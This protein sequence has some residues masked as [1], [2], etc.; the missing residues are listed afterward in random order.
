[1]KKIKAYLSDNRLL[2][3]TVRKAR[4]K[5]YIVVLLLTITILAFF[6]L[7]GEAHAQQ[8]LHEV[9]TLGAIKKDATFNAFIE[10]SNINNLG[11]YDYTITFDKKVLHCQGV[12][13][14][15]F[16]KDEGWTFDVV[17]CTTGS[18]S[19]QI[20][21]N[22]SAVSGSGRM[23]TI[24]FKG[25]NIGIT[26][27]G[28][29]ACTL[30]DSGGNVIAHNHKYA[31]VDVYTSPFPEC[32]IA[33]AAYGSYMDSNVD[34]LRKFRDSYLITNPIGQE[35]VSA[36]YK[37]SPPVARFIDDH[38]GS[39]PVV[40]AWLWPAVALSTVAINTTLIQKVAIVGGLALVCFAT[41]WMLRRRAF[42]HL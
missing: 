25:L 4:A 13:E 23:A 22:G 38:P 26:N 7:S 5:W 15:S 32:F 41:V 35:L 36:Y 1:M 14:G 34:V 18:G 28:I 3:K 19:I 42:R 12:Y 33:T 16:T 8:P 40:R 9:D 31:T 27:I 10:I 29:G 39:K 37:L 20:M 24:Q 11:S 2:V 30:R 17:G 21:G 6:P